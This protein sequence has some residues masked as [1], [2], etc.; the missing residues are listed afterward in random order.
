MKATLIESPEEHHW[1]LL[2]SRVTQLLI[3]PRSFRFQTWSLDAS[4]EVRIG[5]PFALRLPSG[6]ERTLDPEQTEGL[7]PAL[8]I[9]R[10]PLQNLTITRRGELTVAFGDGLTIVV[11]PHPRYEAWEVQGGGSLE[12]MVYTC[13]VGGG[14]PWGGERG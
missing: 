10:R 5:A 13:D 9:L 12:G 11:R 4:L 3:D 14:S 7:A 1:V 8:G 2:D 6:V